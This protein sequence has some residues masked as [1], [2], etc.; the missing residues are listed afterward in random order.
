MI[1]QNECFPLCFLNVFVPHLYTGLVRI[2]I[3]IKDFDTLR[4]Q[5]L[6]AYKKETLCPIF[7]LLAP[8]DYSRGNPNR[9]LMKLS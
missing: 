9:V 4:K 6:E 5:I 7:C 8:V 3:L 1:G 2:N